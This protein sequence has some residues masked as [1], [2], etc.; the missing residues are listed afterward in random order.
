M[1]VLQKRLAMGTVGELDSPPEEGHKGT[2]HTSS[3]EGG[4][5]GGDMMT[6]SIGAHHG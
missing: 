4:F 3:K 5:K 6:L 1:Q 2:K